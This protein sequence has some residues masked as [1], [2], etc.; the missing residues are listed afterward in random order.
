MEKE[1]Q[2][3]RVEANV[4]H[5]MPAT[6]TGQ[7][8]SAS[9]HPFSYWLRKNRYYH[10]C[11]KKFYRFVVSPEASV[12]HVNC[13]NGYLLDAMQPLVG[14]GVDTNELFIT[15]ARQQYKE[16]QFYTGSVDAITVSHKFDY[17]V[18]SL[19]TMEVD[20]VQALFQQLHRFV[21][22]GTRVIVETYSYLWE[23]VLWLTQKL[24]LRRPT[25]FKNWLSR[26]DV[27]NFLYLAGFEAVTTGSYVLFPLWIPFFSWFCNVLLAPLP[28]IRTLC[29][30][31]WLIARPK[32]PVRRLEDSTVSVIVACCNERGNIERVVR[33]CPMMGRGTEIIFVEGNSTDGTL[34]EIK[35]VAEQYKESHN[36][37]WYVQDG[38]GKGDAVRKGFAY[39]KGDVLMILDADLT[40]PAPELSKFFKALV[41]GKG[42]LINGS[43]LVYGMESEAMRF[44]NLITN[45]CF[46]L[47]FSWTLGQRI[48]DT[49]C[50]TKVMW[51]KDYE[52][53]ARQR[54]AFGLHD[55]FGDF[56]LIF[57]AAKLNL[58]IVDMPIRYKNRT[59]GTTKIGNK[60]RFRHGVMLLWMNLIAMRKFKFR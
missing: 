51:K 2:K 35:R 22:P 30:Q 4:P 39:A 28:L 33:E 54:V 8:E 6:E 21:H 16:F 29:L 58:K 15:E 24:G 44:L 9:Q 49:L 47:S 41:S 37:S 56:D 52:C 38:I 10:A 19:V 36:I 11:I 18:L 27:D 45:F 46:G 40:M 57:G 26:Y 59:Y 13:K 60:G 7:N 55:P 34:D 5:K 48:K 32:P 17:V 23:P 1:L 3:T 50:G 53:L 25:R 42:E 14:V 31:Q 20:D 43:R 12:L